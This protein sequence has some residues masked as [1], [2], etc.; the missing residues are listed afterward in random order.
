MRAWESAHGGH[1]HTFEV[2]FVAAIL[3]GTPL[4][5]ASTGELLSETVGLFDIGIEGLMLIGAAVGVV[6]SLSTGNPELGLLVGALA[7]GA[8]L[9]VFYGVPVVL[10]GTEQ[11]LPG[12]GVWFI[13]LG[14]S[15]LI[16]ANDESV[17]VPSAST[18]VTLP[19]ISHIPVVGALV[20]HYPWPVYFAF[21]LPFFIGWMFRSTRH[22]RAMRAVGEDP[23]SAASGAGIAVVRWRMVYVAFN[24]LLGG[25]AGAVLSVIAIGEWGF[26][27]TAGRGFIALV[28][29]IFAAWRPMRLIVGAY[30]LGGL[31]IL[32]DLGG[33]LS[34]PVPPEFLNMIPYAG[35][36]LILIAWALR[37]SGRG[38]APSALGLPFKRKG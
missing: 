16:G 8:Y 3:A 7:G 10:F 6:I 24:G 5:L 1:V 37:A 28:I 32:A 20:A 15:E 23:V 11:V 33:A 36:V 35:A 18:K 2:Y 22:G 34:W 17:A 13:G 19:G 21:V 4:L 27:V 9:V 31:L 38:V 29:V 30:I 25:F 12:F 14:L 26:D